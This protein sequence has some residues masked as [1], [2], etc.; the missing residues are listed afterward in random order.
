MNSLTL[1]LNV[2][3]PEKSGKYRPTMSPLSFIVDA[4]GFRRSALRVRR[5]EQRQLTTRAHKAELLDA[6]LHAQLHPAD[7]H[8][9]I[10]D[11]LWHRRERAV[12]Y[13]D[14]HDRKGP[15]AAAWAVERRCRSMVGPPSQAA[16]RSPGE[17][18]GHRCCKSCLCSRPHIG[19]AQESECASPHSHIV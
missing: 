7:D 14:I 11:V 12:R 4:E 6:R 18:A 5:I 19:R 10:V 15:G 2:S 3:F 16:S 17:A 13:L 9:V 1:D 8:P